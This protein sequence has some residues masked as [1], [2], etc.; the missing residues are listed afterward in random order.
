M[1]TVVG[2]SRN[3]IVSGAFEELAKSERRMAR[4]QKTYQSQPAPS[5]NAKPPRAKG[6]KQRRGTK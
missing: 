1:A 4:I 2:P 5:K 6:S 3:R